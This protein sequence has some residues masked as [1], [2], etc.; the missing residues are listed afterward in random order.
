MDPG[1]PDFRRVLEVFSHTSHVRFNTLSAHIGTGI[2]DTAPYRLLAREMNAL[3]QRLVSD[4]IRIETLDFG[5]GF[6]VKS[7]IRF[8]HRRFDDFDAAEPGTVPALDAVATFEDCCRVMA[9]ELPGLRPSIIL[10]PGR[11]LVSD[12]FHLITRVVRM[13]KQHGTSWAILDAGRIQNALFT[14]RGYHDM[15]H[16]TDPLGNADFDYT[17]V[18]PLCAGF[19]VHARGRRFPALHEGDALMICDVGAYNL[20]AQSAWSFPPAPVV[21]IAGRDVRRL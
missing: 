2:I 19:D 7:E 13:K 8:Q 10:E 15:F 11:L 12:A 5:G 4:G 20:S 9:E 21:A 3:R 14:A 16:V 18:G 6:S 1:D 17:L